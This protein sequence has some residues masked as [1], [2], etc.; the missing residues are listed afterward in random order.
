[1]SNNNEKLYH[2]PRRVDEGIKIFGMNGRAWILMFLFIGIAIL[3]AYI[4]PFSTGVKVGIAAF[5]VVFPY[6]LFTQELGNGLFA[7]DYV[8]L[9]IGNMYAQKYI[10]S[11]LLDREQNTMRNISLHLFM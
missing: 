6:F 3:V 5:L 11:H 9:L 8:K 4:F 2:I 10:T 1:M 7:I